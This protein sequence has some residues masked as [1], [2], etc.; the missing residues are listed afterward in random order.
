MTSGLRLTPVFGHLGHRRL[1]HDVPA[2]GTPEHSALLSGSLDLDAIER[3]A[4]GPLVGFAPIVL[5]PRGP[6]PDDLVEP[7]PPTEVD[8]PSFPPTSATR[9]LPTRRSLRAAGGASA[10]SPGASSGAPSLSEGLLA[11][12]LP[13]PRPVSPVSGAPRQAGRSG[14]TTGALG[15]QDVQ[16]ALAA[17]PAL[18]V[19]DDPTPTGELARPF[20]DTAAATGWSDLEDVPPPVSVDVFQRAVRAGLALDDAESLKALDD[21]TELAGDPSR[22]AGRSRRELRARERARTSTRSVTGRRLAKGGVLVITALGVVSGAAPQSLNA[23]G[24]GK[25]PSA[26]NT[27]DFASALAPDTSA[28]ALTPIQVEQVRH[29]ALAGHL[30]R[31][32][33]QDRQGDAVRAGIGVGGAMAELASEQDARVQADRKA[34]QQ[35][36]V[37]NVIADPQAYARMAVADRGWGPMQF[38][39]LVSLWDKESNWNYR[40]SNPSSGA[41]GIAQALP[42]GKM[43][44]V[45]PDWRT[46]P[47]TQIKWGL[48]YIADRYGTP[49]GAWAHSQATGWY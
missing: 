11:A 49:C 48:N 25:G 31:E 9:I 44:I 41:Y 17:C 32:L 42:G 4:E 12:A 38:R 47:V 36:A 2:F 46:N 10:A 23:F 19:A 24:L 28:P 18:Q 30:D 34:A 8:E 27:I 39:C 40:A 29:A 21:E 37:R 7:G 15:V 3:A 16:Q 22:R 14:P 43:N 1:G 20:V 33:E 13:S 5:D 45:G 6:S 35:Q 26:R